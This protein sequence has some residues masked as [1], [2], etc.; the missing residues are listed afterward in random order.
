MQRG[1]TCLQGRL[2]SHSG[3]GHR[4]A[5]SAVRLWAAGPQGPLPAARSTEQGVT[6]PW[7]PATPRAAE[8]VHKTSTARGL[9]GGTSTT[10]ASHQADQQEDKHSRVP[11]YPSKR[12]VT[13]Q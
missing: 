12:D 3:P 1:R 13:A 5:R 9:P 6:R 2:P 11:S 7:G 10:A 8:H 4:A